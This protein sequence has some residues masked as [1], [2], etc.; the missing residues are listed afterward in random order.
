MINLTRL[1]VYLFEGVAVTIAIYLV[2][3]KHLQLRDILTLSLSIGETFLILD[4]FAPGV[5][6][7]TRQ[8]PARR[9]GPSCAGSPP[10]SGARRGTRTAR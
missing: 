8:G 10:P 3:R 2:T 6:A 1:L 4:L 9:A 7:G 5:A